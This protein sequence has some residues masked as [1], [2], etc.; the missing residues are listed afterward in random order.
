VQAKPFQAEC[1]QKGLR[2]QRLADILQMIQEFISAR[3]RVLVILAT[4]LPGRGFFAF[5]QAI[6]SPQETRAD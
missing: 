5:C 1:A 4:S 2:C 6:F 3:N